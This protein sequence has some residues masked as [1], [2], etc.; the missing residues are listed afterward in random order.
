[1]SSELINR[2]KV[3]DEEEVVSRAANAL[4]APSVIYRHVHQTWVRGME[5]VWGN[6]DK[7]AEVLAKLG[8]DAAEVFILSGHCRTFLE[9]VNP[10][11]TDEM[12]AKMKPFT[13][14]EDG[15]VTLDDGDQ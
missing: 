6:P 11:C 8:P 14:N 10:G 5:N 15:T 9:A 2:P 12:Y 4:R 13:I 1:M 7:T 3:F